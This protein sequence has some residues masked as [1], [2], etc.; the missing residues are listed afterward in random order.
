MPSIKPPHDAPHL[1]KPPP[2]EI[3]AAVKNTR[4]PL[5]LRAPHGRWLPGLR[6][7]SS[8]D[9]KTNPSP[10]DWIKDV[11]EPRPAPSA[12]SM[13]TVSDNGLIAM[14]A[15]RRDHCLYSPSRRTTAT[16]YEQY[17][18]LARQELSQYARTGTRVVSSR[19]SD[20]H[21]RHGVPGYDLLVSLGDDGKLV[22]GID[23]NCETKIES[24]Q[25]TV[26]L[27]TVEPR[28]DVESYSQS[29]LCGAL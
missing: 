19:R 20:A 14:D 4:Q 12:D 3:L 13:Q 8:P 1:S 25:C 11:L 7:R 22:S 6:R 29:N 21:G 18:P 16:C 15:I 17:P 2:K 28:R 26:T 5:R 27:N 10:T 24:A 23:C 9:D